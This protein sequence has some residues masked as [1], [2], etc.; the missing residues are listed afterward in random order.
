[1]TRAVMQAADEL[2]DGRL[3]LVHE[4]GYSEVLCAV[5]RPCGAGR[6]C[7]AAPPAPDPLAATLAKRQPG[8]VW[9]R[10]VSDHIAELAQYFL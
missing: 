1:M 9:Q 8:A 2:C 4:G 6:D 7:P 10:H 5:L 3:T